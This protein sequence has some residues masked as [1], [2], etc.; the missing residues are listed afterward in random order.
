MGI[1]NSKGSSLN[2]NELDISVMRENDKNLLTVAPSLHSKVSISDLIFSLASKINIKTTKRATWLRQ[3]RMSQLYT[4]KSD[5]KHMASFKFEGPP[6]PR[7]Y[8]ENTKSHFSPL[9]DSTTPSVNLNIY[10]QHPD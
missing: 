7:I 8:A 6:S 9:Q 3:N 4:Q 5:C 1:N 10:P 2:I